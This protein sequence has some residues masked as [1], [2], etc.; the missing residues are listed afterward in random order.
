MSGPTTLFPSRKVSLMLAMTSC[1]VLALV[2]LEPTKARALQ[3][4]LVV[5]VADAG[6]QSF[7]T[8]GLQTTPTLQ[9]E[10]FD[11]RSSVT[12][13]SDAG[14]FSGSGSMSTNA[15]VYGGAGGTGRFPTAANMVLTMPNT[16]DYRYVG[17]WWSAGNSNNHVDILDINDNVLATFTVDIANS[18]E[19]LQGVVGSCSGAT[20]L[21]NG[22]CGNPN[23]TINGTTYGSRQVANEPF[24]FV[25]LRYEP[26]F[27]KVRFRGTGFEMDNV[28]ISQ[29][30]PPLSST[31]TTT[32]T[33]VQYTVSTPS[34]LIADPRSSTISF[35]GVTL[36]AGTG[37]TNAMLCFSQV[38]QTGG[39]ITGSAEIVA[40]G[41]GTGVTF[42]SGTNLVTFSGARDTVVSFSPSVDFQSVPSGDRFGIGSIYL[43][44]VA[45]PQTNAGSSGCTGD[46]AVSVVIEVR[47]L[48]LFLSDSV[49][50][51]I[52]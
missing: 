16:S 41:S 21:N 17:F 34:V 42:S 27:R 23:L 29:T 20:P 18:T 2:W 36:G 48:N 8:S 52:D 28:T 51:P 44:V 31:E 12:F 9:V 50:I 3:S 1:I 19:D 14:T 32:E 15:N 4:D 47:F 43:R 10:N 11:S 33:F 46:A 26:G 40:A 5:T 30:S 25:H 6:I 13:T 24:A 45:T 37:E 39:A 22:Y 38:T 35:P 7:A 49:G